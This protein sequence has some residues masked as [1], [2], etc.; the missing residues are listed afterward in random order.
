MLVC[1]TKYYDENQTKGKTTMRVLL[2]SE[3]LSVSFAQ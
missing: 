3:L 2:K 1:E